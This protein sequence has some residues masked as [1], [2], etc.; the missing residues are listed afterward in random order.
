MNYN[1]ILTLLPDSIY[2]TKSGSNNQKRW[3]LFANQLNEVEAVFDDLRMIYD[4][5][6]Q[7]GAVLD[8]I[9]E[10]L[11]EPRNGVNDDAYII[12]L[13]LALQKLLCNGSI[14]ALQDVLR[15]IAGDDFI[16]V[17]DLTPGEEFE[18]M[19]PHENYLNGAFYLDGSFFLSGT[20]FQSGYIDVVCKNSISPD[21]LD[22]ITKV[23]NIIKSAGVKYRIRQVEA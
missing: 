23:M 16:G 9:G 17:W 14:P 8:L 7:S 5:N 20:V 13:I 15:A 19:S 4:I 2:T 21:I 12:Y 6:S 1:D 11:R 18:D 10:I 22:Y 3:A